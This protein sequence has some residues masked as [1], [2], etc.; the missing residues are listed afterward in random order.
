MSTIFGICSMKTGHASMQAA[1]VVHCHRGA[2][3]VAGRVPMMARGLTAS[4]SA[5]GSLSAGV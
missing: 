3:D 2:G 1:Q 5:V 4:T